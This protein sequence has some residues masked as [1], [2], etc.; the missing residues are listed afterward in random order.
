MD[1]MDNDSVLH[2]LFSDFDNKLGNFSSS[3]KRKADTKELNDEIS[4]FSKTFVD[5]QE[6]LF[7][8]GENNAGSSNQ[9]IPQPHAV[10]SSIEMPELDLD[11]IFVDSDI[12]DIQ[13]LLSGEVLS[14]AEEDDKDEEQLDPTELSDTDS[15]DEQEEEEVVSKVQP[16]GENQETI[17]PVISTDQNSEDEEDEARKYRILHT[18]LFE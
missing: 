3:I 18:F 7:S 2:S 12:L 1:N 14:D 6:S 15:E 4:K 9:P 10:G 5:K 16:V 13:K 11:E 17:T 8:E